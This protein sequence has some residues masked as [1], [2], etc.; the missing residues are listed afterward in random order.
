MFFSL[1]A[2]S[3]DIDVQGVLEELLQQCREELGDRVPNAGILHCPIDID[4][5]ML[6]EGINDA[7]PGMALV[8]CTTDGEFSSRL[9]FRE[10][11]TSLTLLG[12]DIVD[13]TAGLGR[14]VSRDIAAA[15]SQAIASAT[16]NPRKPA[17][18]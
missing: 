13:M 9:G 3:E 2:H 4:H 16:A 12:S 14:E 11:S 15:C 1:V 5:E 8:G 6:V 7:W 17:T 10:D 18:L